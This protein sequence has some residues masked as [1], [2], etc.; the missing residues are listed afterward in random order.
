MKK[1]SKLLLLF[2]LVTFSGVCKSQTFTANEF[3]NL[4]YVDSDKLRDAIEKKGY[5][6]SSSETS[7]MSKNDVYAGGNNSSIYV[8]TPNFE[9]GENLIS[10]EF[11]GMDDLYKELQNQLKTSGYKQLEHEVR[12][13]ARYTVTTYQKPG[14]TVTLSR[15]KLKSKEGIYRL[16]VRYTNAN[17][18][19]EI[20]K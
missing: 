4:S 19:R 11:I 8:I 20:T 14:I 7:D 17:P 15:D 12:N 9:S 5:T 6:F 2:A 1:F 10:W 3:I 16:S 13:G 18:Y